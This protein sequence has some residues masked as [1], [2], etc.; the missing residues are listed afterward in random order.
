MVISL[1]GLVG[2]QNSD[3]TLFYPSGVGHLSMWHLAPP[4]FIDFVVLSPVAICSYSTGA[5]TDPTQP[6]SEKGYDVANNRV[7]SLA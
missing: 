7:D 2:L 4:L 5:M 1:L 3:F 6:G